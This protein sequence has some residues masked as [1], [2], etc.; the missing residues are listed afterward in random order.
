MKTKRIICEII[1]FLLFAVL[2]VYSCG[3]LSKAFM[4]ERESYGSTWNM[5]LNE[6]KDS[7]DVMFFGSSMAYCDIVPA[8]IYAN[9]GITSYVMT[10]PEMTVPQGYYYI[11]ESFRTQS[12][13]VVFFELS[14]MFFPDYSNHTA[15]TVGFMP[16]S[17]NRIAATFVTAEPRARFSLLFPMYKYHDRW[18]EVSITQKRADDR[19]DPFAGYTPTLGVIE[20]LEQRREWVFDNTNVRLSKNEE[21]LR[22]IEKLCEKENTELIFFL[23]PA[24]SNYSAENLEIIRKAAGDTPFI[25]FNG[26][27][28]TIGFDMKTDFYDPLHLNLIGALK[29]SDRLSEY[30]GESFEF[31]EREHDK[32]LWQ[33]RILE[34]EKLLEVQNGQ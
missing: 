4:P 9:T 6:P 14:G 17:E 18:Q 1:A 16:Y 8:Q 20:A 26:E 22:K 24:C 32:A 25:D 10:A 2:L 21:Y 27:F 15:E 19:I 11:K 7:V 12:P 31:P 5:Y 3:F 30:I 23:A 29:F 34:I 33:N 13:E 28:D